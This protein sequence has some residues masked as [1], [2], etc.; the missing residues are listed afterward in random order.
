M[1]TTIEAQTK[2]PAPGRELRFLAD[3]YEQA[4]RLRIE[5]GERI[6]AVVQGRDATWPGTEAWVEEKT[7]EVMGQMLEHPSVRWSDLL[8]EVRYL[9]DEL[10]VS[11]VQALAPQKKEQDEEEVDGVTGTLD[12]EL[13]ADQAARE[14]GSTP[15][16]VKR[17]AAKVVS[18]VGEVV[19]LE[20]GR[21]DEPGPV[22]IMGRAYHRYSAEEEASLKDMGEALKRHPAFPWLKQVRGIGPSLGCKLLARLDPTEAPHASSFWAYCGLGT[23]E[24]NEYRCPECG[25]VKGWPVGY[26][27]TGEHRGCS[28]KLV[29]VRGPED[30]VRVAQPRPRKGE[31]ATYDQHMKKVVL[32]QVVPSFLKVG[33]PYER[34]WRREREKADRTR[35]GWAEGRKKALADRKTVKLFLSHLWQVWR[36]A[37]ELPAGKPWAHAH[38]PGEDHELITPEEMLGD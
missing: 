12:V 5:V 31:K 14:L 2:R 22:P 23:V 27:V 35:P 34:Y 38:E 33:G 26:N 30:G 6:R 18:R 29:K 15:S 25:L 11:E 36:E 7:R 3:N 4:Q 10:E 17:A 19:L 9:R 8:D 28:G 16:R 21:G 24:G 32:G 13:L 1:T 20:V 37:L